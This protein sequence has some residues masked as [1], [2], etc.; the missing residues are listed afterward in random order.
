MA[1]MLGR[2]TLQERADLSAAFPQR[3]LAVVRITTLAG[4]QFVSDVTAARGD[5]AEPLTDAELLPKFE[6][7]GGDRNPD[8]WRAIAETCLKLGPQT[9]SLEWSLNL[10]LSPV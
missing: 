1:T 6:A 2:I 4:D 8:E 3:R 5:P 7:A 9:T 10:V